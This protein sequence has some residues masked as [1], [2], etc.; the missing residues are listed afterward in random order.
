MNTETKSIMGAC[1]P[2][3][4]KAKA[5]PSGRHPFLSAHQIWI[6]LCRER[7]CICRPLVESCRRKG[8]N[9][10]PDVLGRIAEAMMEAPNVETQHLDTHYV[11][12]DLMDGRQV[13]AGGRNCPIFRLL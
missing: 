4:R 10:G 12:F 3:L 9:E 11:V 5:D 7:H 2:I 1:L 6:S 8:S 13:G